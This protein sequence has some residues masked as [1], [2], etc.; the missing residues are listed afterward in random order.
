MKASPD[1][2]SAPGSSFRRLEVVGSGEANGEYTFVPRDADENERLT[3]WMTVPAYM[4]VP[5]DQYR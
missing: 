4:V 5:L 3:A 1:A 2:K